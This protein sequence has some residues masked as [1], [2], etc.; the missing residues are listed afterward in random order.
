[1]I[2]WELPDFSRKGFDFKALEAHIDIKDGNV[3]I[4]NFIFKSTT[5][6]ATAQG[7]IFLPTETVDFYFWIQTLEALDFVV[8]NV[9][10]IGYI[11]TEKENSPKG[12]IIYPLEV[13]GN[14]SNPNVKSSVLKNLGP[15]VINIFKRILLS[16]G[17]IFKEISEFTKG[18]VTMNGSQDEQKPEGDNPA[19]AQ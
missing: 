19:I 6:N 12:V 17:H 11:L 9:P 14:W 15:G 4:D 8:F 3:E 5:F 16:P 10:I 1:M 18:I 7:N 13:D 2:K